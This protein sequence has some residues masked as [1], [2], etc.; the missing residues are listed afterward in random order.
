MGD[1]ARSNAMWGGR[2]ASGPD[3]VMEAINASIGFDR[4]LYREDIEASRAHAAMLG[5][6][7]IIADSDAAAIRE[8][9]LT[10]LS[11]IEA[12]G[13]PFS[14]VILDAEMPGTDGLGVLRHIRARADYAAL[15]VVAVSQHKEPD[16]CERAMAIGASACVTKLDRAELQGVLSAL[17]PDGGRRAA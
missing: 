4:R 2:F 12:G 3:A 8:G 6:T 1:K 7:G 15:P 11:E 16:T 9:L 5:A 10:V 13:F 17:L 14:A